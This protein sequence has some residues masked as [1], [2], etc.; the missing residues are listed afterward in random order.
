M[1]I[2]ISFKCLHIECWLIHKYVFNLTRNSPIFSPSSCLDFHCL[3]AV[4]KDSDDCHLWAVALEPALVSISLKQVW[5]HCEAQAKAHHTTLTAW[6]FLEWSMLH[7]LGQAVSGVCCE[8]SC[9]YTGISRM[10]PQAA[11]AVVYWLLIA[12][13]KLFSG[14]DRMAGTRH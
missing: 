6:Q 1:L 4:P 7:S 2:F 12:T 13:L 10:R 9:H 8:H 14:R 5:F 3:A 11:G